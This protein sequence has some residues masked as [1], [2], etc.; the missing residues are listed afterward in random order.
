MY[1]ILNLFFHIQKSGIIAADVACK[2]DHQPLDSAGKY[3]DADS[4]KLRECF[5]LF[6]D[7]DADYSGF[8]SGKIYPGCVWNIAAGH[9]PIFSGKT[10]AG[11]CSNSFR[12]HDQQ[13]CR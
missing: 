7:H 6:C 10:A 13:N 11:V 3:P 8:A 4:V 12:G 5:D 2:T 1:L 9:V